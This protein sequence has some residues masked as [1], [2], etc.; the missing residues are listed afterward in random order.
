[1]QKKKFV[2][3]RPFLFCAISLALGIFSAYLFTLNNIVF[4]VITVCISI[5]LIAT[6]VLFSNLKLKSGLFF[7][8]AFLLVFLIGIL[9]FNYRVNDY[10]TANLNSHYYTVT[11]KVRECVPTSDG[12]KV[13]VDNARVDGANYGNLKY[14]IV[15]YVIGELNVD[16]GDVII[17]DSYLKDKSIFYEDNFSAHDIAN[18]YK[19]LAQVEANDVSVVA[20]S[21]TI[22][23]S[24]NLF[25]RDTLKQGLGEQEFSV[26]YAMLLGNTDYIDYDT[27]TSYRSS[28]IAHIFAV[29]GLHIGFLA[30]ALNFILKKFKIN[31]LVKAILVSIILFGYAGICGFSASSIRA[32]VMCSVMLFSAVKGMR[33]DGLSSVGVSAFLIL[34]FQPIQLFCVGFQL[35]FAVVLGIIVLSPI[36]MRLFKFMPQKIASPLSTV[37][38]AQL[39]GIPICLASF[40]QFSAVAIIFNLLFI[41]IISVVFIALLL[42]TILGGIFGIPYVALYLLNGVLWLINAIITAFDYD[43]FIIGGFSLG[44]FALFYYLALIV[45]SGLIKLKGKLKGIIAIACALICIGGSVLTNL[46]LNTSA[47]VYV[48]GNSNVCATVIQNQGENVMIVSQSS[49]IWSTSRFNRL[50]NKTGINNIDFLIFTDGATSDMQTFISKLR[51]VFSIDSVCYYG[52]QD[53]EME[54]I[55]VKSFNIDVRA[56]EDDRLSSI[57]TQCKFDLNGKAVTCKVKNQ[58]ILIFSSCSGANYTGLTDEY[59]LVVAL[60]LEEQIFAHYD[61]AFKIAY[62]DNLEYKSAESNGTA[63]YK[64]R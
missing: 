1:M 60:D 25:M 6:S 43:I 63:T 58:D 39:V 2:N 46:N 50:K 56:Y 38:S 8:V 55:I 34:L 17:F 36:L 49:K 24:A 14:K 16:I 47:N 27:I 12:N 31:R 26:A 21:L 11:G 37:V 20:K 15:V 30:T 22:F 18:G 35:S 28:G 7:F 13:I 44:A 45:P 40:G 54:D 29:S 52:T 33:Y 5:L 42:C 51:S 41:P 19:Y 64:I 62:R 9:S 23:E 4:A 61:S 48:V 10:A 57:K 53:Y 32:S 59:D 3:F